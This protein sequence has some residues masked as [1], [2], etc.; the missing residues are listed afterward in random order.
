[1]SAST[2][3]GPDKAVVEARAPAQ[4]ADIGAIP[5]LVS[6]RDRVSRLEVQMK[7]L[8]RTWH[9]RYPPQATGAP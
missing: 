9:F 1:V 5:V 7:E 6:A 8:R 2:P 4:Q 3:T